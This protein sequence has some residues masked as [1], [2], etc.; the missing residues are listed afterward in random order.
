MI[1]FKKWKLLFLIKNIFPSWHQRQLRTKVWYRIYE[2]P[3]KASRTFAK[4]KFHSMRKKVVDQFS[5]FIMPLPHNSLIGFLSLIHKGGWGRV[6]GRYKPGSSQTI[7]LKKLIDK[8]AINKTQ[9]GCTPSKFYIFEP[10]IF[11][12]CTFV[13]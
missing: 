5:F 13:I 8:K 3:S 6:K 9:K 4:S 7:F 2:F 12:S 1:L 10:W 11:I